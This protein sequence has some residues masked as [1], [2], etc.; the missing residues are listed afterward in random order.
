MS[1]QVRINRFIVRL[2]VKVMLGSLPS[3]VGAL[4]DLAGKLPFFVI[5]LLLT[6]LEPAGG[7]SMNRKG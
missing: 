7:E 4:L 5:N 2:P 3:F 1:R 6:T